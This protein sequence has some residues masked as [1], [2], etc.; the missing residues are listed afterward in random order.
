MPRQVFAN[1]LEAKPIVGLVV[2][3]LILAAEDLGALE[4]SGDTCVCALAGPNTTSQ[5]PTLH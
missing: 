4:M 2:A 5:Q 3:A 1:L